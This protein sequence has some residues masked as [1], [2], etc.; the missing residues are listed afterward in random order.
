MDFK[1]EKQEPW[2]PALERLIINVIDDNIEEYRRFNNNSKLIAVARDL[3]PLDELAQ[4]AGFDKFDTSIPLLKDFFPAVLLDWFAEEFFQWFEIPRCRWCRGRPEMVSVFNYINIE[5]L[6]VER[7]QCINSYCN[8]YHDFIRHRDPAI[9]LLTRN[10]RCGEFACAF[11]FFLKAAEYDTRV[12]VDV[13][14]HVWNEIY[15]ESE[16]RWVHIDASSVHLDNPYVY[17]LEG[18]RMSYCIAFSGYEVQDV[19]WRYTINQSEAEKRRNNDEI[20]FAKYM[21]YKSIETG[22][23]TE[24]RMVRRMRET[25]SFIRGDKNQIIDVDKDSIR[26]R[27]FDLRSKPRGWKPGRA[28]SL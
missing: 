20:L 12:V 10:G 23:L 15:L 14:D 27:L 19:T 6:Q 18:K 1:I 22:R 25:L 3:A 13:N 7:Y 21:L 9:L 28:L 8:N 24:E 26:R 2:L 4:K 17:E 5:C 11:F 16:K